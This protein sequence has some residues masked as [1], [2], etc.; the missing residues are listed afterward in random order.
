MIDYDDLARLCIEVAECLKEKEPV[1]PV[2]GSPTAK[3]I[4]RED[5]N[6]SR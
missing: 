5:S 1:L 4:T 6:R 3:E 2:T